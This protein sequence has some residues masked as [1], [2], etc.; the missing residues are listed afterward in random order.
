MTD[1]GGLK[2]PAVAAAIRLV[3]TRLLHDE[4]LARKYRRI[5][6]SWFEAR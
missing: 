1:A 3:K 2:Y 6:R 5:S 4:S